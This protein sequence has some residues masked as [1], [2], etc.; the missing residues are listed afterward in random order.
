MVA[1]TPRPLLELRTERLLLRAWR[2]SDREPFAAINADPEVMATLPAPLTRA[3]SD[4]FVDRIE[5]CFHQRG[6][7]LWVL[8]RVDD[9]ACLGYVGLWPADAGP[10]LGFSGFGVRNPAESSGS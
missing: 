6:H 2:D 1:G 10:A 5:A 9:P 3:E 7:G 4:A 8:T